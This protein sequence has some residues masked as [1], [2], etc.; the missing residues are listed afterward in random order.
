MSLLYE[1]K[2]RAREYAALSCNV[3][4]GCD[5]ACSYCYAPSATF[6][7]RNDFVIS[8]PRKNF[9]QLLNQEANNWKGAKD[10]VLLCFTCDPYQALD[11]QTGDT[12]QAIMALHARGF[13]ICTLTK[14]GKRALRDIDLFGPRD[15]FA[16]TLTFLDPA[17]SLE[18]EPGAALPDDRMKT[19][20]AFY[21]TG[22]TTWVSLEPTIDPQQSLEIIRQ[23]HGFV[24]LYKVGKLN[25]H[26]LAQTID[27][28]KYTI[29][30]IE[31]ISGYG[32]DYKIKNDLA[33]F[34]PS[35]LP[36]DSRIKA[37]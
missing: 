22:V 19:L 5:H 34:I 12:R 15:A 17:Q 8:K 4:S 31:L 7:Q 20:S 25:Y 37:I 36:Q 13:P 16:S 1:P 14:G 28:R 10:Q 33:Q 21:E 18:W 27:W 24:D 35:G 11:E 30:A 9:I 3:Y 23:T 29:Q 6:K 26:P 2:G 32:R